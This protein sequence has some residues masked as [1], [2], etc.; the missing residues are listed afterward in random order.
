VIIVLVST[1]AS[2]GV[3]SSGVLVPVSAVVLVAW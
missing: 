3:L 2:S 1:R